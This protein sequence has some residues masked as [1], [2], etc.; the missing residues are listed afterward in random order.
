MSCK[1]ASW[2]DFSKF[3]KKHLRQNSLE[4]SWTRFSFHV[5]DFLPNLIRISWPLQMNYFHHRCPSSNKRKTR[6]I[7]QTNMMI[8]RPIGWTKVKKYKNEYACVVKWNK[9]VSSP[10]S[11][12]PPPQKEQTIENTHLLQ[13]YM[14][15]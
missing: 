12:T 8:L 15:N 3:T 1:K 4:Y 6:C 14:L 10:F 7:L 11:L 5:S 13:L 2:N 9:T